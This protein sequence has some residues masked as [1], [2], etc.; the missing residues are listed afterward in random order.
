MASR[1]QQGRAP[2]RT[3]TGVVVGEGTR[4]WF[5]NKFS[6]VAPKFAA[7][8]HDRLR[9]HAVVDPGLALGGVEEHVGECLLGQGPV[10][11]RA[12]LGVGSAQIRETSDLLMPVSAPRALTKHRP[13]WSRRRAG[14]PPPPQRTRLINPRRRSNRPGKNEPVRVGGPGTGP[15]RHRDHSRGHCRGSQPKGDRRRRLRRRPGPA[16]SDRGIGPGLCAGIGYTGVVTHGGA[17]R[18]DDIAAAL[19]EHCWQRRSAGAGPKGPRHDLAWI[20]LTDRDGT[21]ERA[22]ASL[23]PRRLK[24]YAARLCEPIYRSG[25]IEPSRTLYWNYGRS[26]PSVEPSRTRRFASR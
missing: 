10:A 6:L 7:Y 1:P 19:P 15:G 23:M 13:C 12:D 9:H 22:P 25:P 5:E 24:R 20:A 26:G 16:R 21:G 18:V 3:W 14:R 4:C 2:H 8:G 11:E 17:M